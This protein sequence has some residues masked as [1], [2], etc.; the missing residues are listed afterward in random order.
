MAVTSTAMTILGTSAAAAAQDVVATIKPIHS[1]T[2]QVMEG[3]GSPVLLIDGAADPHSYALRP[4]DAKKLGAARL[5]VMVGPRLEEF[6]DKPLKSLAGKARILQLAKVPGIM[7]PEDEAGMPD[8][9]LW[10]DPV[11]AARA[12]EA[13][14]RALTEID[15]AHGYEYTRNAAQAKDRLLALDRELRQALAPVRDKPFVVYHDAFRGL[16]ARYGLKMTGAVLSGAEHVARA[17]A[18]AFLTTRGAQE[19]PLCL[20]TAPQFEPSLARSIS[21]ATGARIAELDDLG[22]A[23]PKGPEMYFTLMRGIAAGLRDCLGEKN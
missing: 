3:I 20:F 1:L 18:L 7:L 8:P 6:L 21:D 10:L 19:R 14:G 5:V 11:N 23:I 12:V 16:V 9:H 17:R 4:A 13:I 15:P 2:A 22:A